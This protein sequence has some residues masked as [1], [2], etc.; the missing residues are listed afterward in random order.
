M[1]LLAIQQG[2]QREVV[3]L[4]QAEKTLCIQ[5]MTAICVYLYTKAFSKKR[6]AIM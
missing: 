5:I 2:K 6:K 3:K 1:Y 4:Q